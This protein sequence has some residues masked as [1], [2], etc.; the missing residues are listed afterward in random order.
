VGVREAVVGYPY[1]SGSVLAGRSLRLV[2]QR[3][4]QLTLF[5]AAGWLTTLGA[6]AIACLRRI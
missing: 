3:I 1:R 6:C 2:E 5:V 4:D